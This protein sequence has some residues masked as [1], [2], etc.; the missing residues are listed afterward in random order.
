VNEAARLTELAKTV[1][2]RVL[3]SDAALRMADPAESRRWRLGD[4][5]TLRGRTAPTRLATPAD[6]GG[7]PPLGRDAEPYPEN[8]PER[9]A[10]G[11]GEP[12]A[13]RPNATTP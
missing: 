1:P 9:M 7:R 11:T 5:M 8:E 12:P 13:D 4:A 3:A 6:T 2:G 10:P